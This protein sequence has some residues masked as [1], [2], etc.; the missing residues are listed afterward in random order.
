MCTEAPDA[1]DLNVI[2]DVFKLFSFNS[3]PRRQ[4]DRLV[5]DFVERFHLL[6][7]TQ[8]RIVSECVDLY[9]A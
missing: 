3:A 1:A 6:A 9:S 5:L 8:L 7:F 2:F 4:F